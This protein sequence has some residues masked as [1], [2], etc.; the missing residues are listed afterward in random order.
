[1]KIIEYHTAADRSHWLEEIGKSTWVAGRYLYD[2]L[3]K[4][5]L[6]ALCGQ[7]T[8]VLLLTE[9][10]DLVSFCT[11]EGF[12]ACLQGVAAHAQHVALEDFRLLSHQSLRCQEC[13]IC[14]SD[15]R[16]RH[17]QRGIVPDDKSL[18]PRLHCTG[19]A[20]A[21]HLYGIQGRL[22]LPCFIETLYLCHQSRCLL[23]WIGRTTCQHKQQD[24]KSDQFL[25]FGGKSNKKTHVREFL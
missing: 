21:Q 2:L 5:R 4:D 11:T 6:G 7:D 22:V 19:E 16:L 9:G 25:H 24:K 13:R 18:L 12:I 17:L 14:N 23:F 1:M 10:E 15:I 3:R 8:K 20:H